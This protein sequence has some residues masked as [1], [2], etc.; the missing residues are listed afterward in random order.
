MD[1][2]IIGMVMRR[3]VLTLIVMFAITAIFSYGITKMDFYSQFLDLFPAN[4]PYVQMHKKF[5]DYFGGAN[6]ATLV[7][8]VKEGDVFTPET[9]TKMVNIQEAVER[10]GGV[11]P[12]QIFSIASP[13]VMETTEIA[14]GYKKERLMKKIPTNESDMFDLKATVFTNEAYG[15][16][17]STDLK[18]LKLQAT[19]IEGRIDYKALFDALSKIKEKEQDKNH[20]IYM[21]GEPVLYGWIYHYVF[22]TAIIFLISCVIL[23]VLLFFFMGRQPA[24]WIPLVSAML[25]AIWGLGMSGFLGYQFDP[26]IIVVPFLLTARAMSHGVQWLNRFGYEF[27][28]T[29]DAQQACHTTGVQLFY[30]CI[31]GVVTDAAGV[32]IVALIPIPLLQHLAILG[33]FWGMSVI[34]TV[35]IFNPVFV[36]FLPLKPGAFEEN[37][38]WAFLTNMMGNMAKFSITR[39]GKW[40]LVTGSV[41]IFALSF[42]G[43]VNV[44]IGDVNPGSPILWPDSDYNQ[45]VDGINRHFLGMEQM[46]IQVHGNP[47][48]RVSVFLPETLRAMDSL[49]DYLINKGDVVFGFSSADV[50]RSFNCLVHGNDPKFDIIPP[51]MLDVFQILTIFYM[52]AA[53]ED[54]D[55]YMSPG[56]AD[57]NVRLFLKD[58]KGDTLKNVIKDTK[59]WIARPEN[60][61][62]TAHMTEPGKMVEAVEFKPAGGLGGILA[63]ANELIEKAN[64]FLVVGILAFIFL[65]C[66]VIYRSLFAGF[67]FVVS[68]IL[69]NFVAFWYMSAKGIGLNI[70][71]VPVVSLGV[72]LG[73][74]YGLYIVSQIQ[75]LIAAGATWEKGIV[76]GVSSTGRAVF[77]QAVM[78][79]AG[80][81]FWWFSPFRF[82]AEM[83]FLLAILMM[84]NMLVGVLL[85]PSL[86][87]IFKP[88]FIAK[89]I[90][91]A[92]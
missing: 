61:I 86:I 8:E 71:T 4:H 76:E 13:R 18:A 3:R 29:G 72:G 65:C 37:P 1:K 5:K 22:E 54:I 48:A 79:S 52:D 80:V 66:A 14:G 43:F 90:K 74:D 31:I 41:I 27:R 81:F 69:A 60:K 83:G 42:R 9:L 59:E 38:H 58:H 64:D 24:W 17:V 68:M 87:H 45:S 10:L 67:I 23:V 36:S 33:F 82:Q 19:F 57:A 88:G 85:L 56:F 28:R 39:N 32:L 89:S 35:T 6:N 50:I 25:S 46:Y 26:L 21:A 77:Y 34:F 55:Q 78:M 53:P 16:W 30:P 91:Q 75:E 40:I 70:N 63:A 84:V 20:V 51:T 47:E 11:N 12:Y 49:K 2:W 62:M 7:L 92:G 73:V 15:T 44:P